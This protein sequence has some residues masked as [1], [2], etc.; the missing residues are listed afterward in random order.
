SMKTETEHIKAVQTEAKKQLMITEVQRNINYLI[1]KS[2]QMQQRVRNDIREHVYEAHIIAGRI[3]DLGRGT[4]PEDQL[5]RVIIETLRPIRFNKGRGYYFATDLNG[6]E[7]LFADR[8]EMEHKNLMDIQDTRGRYV[9]RDMIGIVRDQGEG[10]YE[11]TWTKPGEEA[12]DFPKMAFVKL[13]EPFNFFIGTGEYLDDVTG[14]IQQEALARISQIRFGNDGYIFV[15][16]SDG[17]LLSHPDADLIGENIRKFEDP[18]GIQV[19]QVLIDASSRPGGDFVQ[20]TWPKPS[21]GKQALKLSFAVFFQDWN[22]IIGTGVYLDDLEEAIAAEQEKYRHTVIRQILFILTLFISFIVIS[23]LI[24]RFISGKLQKG[25]DRFI[26]FFRE[27]AASYEKID[28]GE[29]GFAEF[30]VIGGYANKLVEDFRA[31]QEELRSERDKAQSYLDT[32]GVM[33]VALDREG[34]VALINR[35]GCEILGCEEHEI[36]GMNWFDT[37]IPGSDRKK[38]K[39]IFSGIMSGNI[40]QYEYAENS[41]VTTAGTEKKI[42]WHNALLRDSDGQITGA[43]SSG[44]DIT[45]RKHA[46]KEIRESEARFRTMFEGTTDGILVADPL[47]RQFIAANT[48]ICEML[49]Y[50]HEEIKTLS[51]YD[52]HSPEDVE[53]VLEQFEKQMEGSIELVHD[54][55]VR[56]RDGSIFYA[57]IRSSPI[58]LDGKPFLMGIFRDITERRQVEEQKRIYEISLLH[59]QKME[60]IGTLAGGIAHDF[61]NILSAIIGYT[62]LCLMEDEGAPRIRS[63]HAEILKAGNR[64]RD[65]VKQ[66]LTFSRHEEG[67]E[68]PV[69]LKY[70]VKEVLKLLRPS[71]PVTIEIRQDIRSEG[72]VMA[73][74]TQIHQVIMNLCTNAANAMDTGSGVLSIGVDETMLDA[75][76]AIR[77][78]AREPGHY[79]VLTVSDTGCGMTQDIMGRIFDPYFTTK[80]KDKGTGLGLAVVHGIVTSNRG[81]INVESE[82]GKGT[83]FR[84]YLPRIVMAVEKETVPAPAIPTGNER[85]LFVDDEPA[86]TSIVHQMLESL[87]YAVTTTTDS[88]HALDLFRSNPN[89]FDLVI[90]D[91]TMPKMT[92]ETLVQEMFKIRSDIPVI[93][94]TGYSDI[95]SEE[96]SRKMGIRDFALKPILKKDLA[97]KIRAVLDQH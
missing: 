31:S 16:S 13:F 2:S 52:I 77:L 72:M 45:E 39:E 41:V 8:P 1:F 34:T 63:Y 87:G 49:G 51:V 28:P 46:E 62:E 24:T 53:W 82:P 26:S 47:T 7:Q 81:T 66:I 93:L 58:V 71:L 12:R 68:K 5:R 80:E 36:L 64:A 30:K 29:L 78:N 74:P 10:F 27:S 14:D 92:G 11:Y 94:C 38:V 86:L 40:Q 54:I 37:F 4:M 56:K 75:Q 21:T 25:I 33:F 91:M 65:L 35:K 44:E 43:L 20:Y 70:M 90:T 42:A 85:I 97:A 79:M 95:M 73:D 6:I 76:A 9:I 89:L 15:M 69:I 57:D 22:W 3:Y 61:N 59:S 83:T 88:V 50:S 84:I 48:S 60:A 23:L 17:V 18:D 96:K 32:A 19:G 67:Q 55:P